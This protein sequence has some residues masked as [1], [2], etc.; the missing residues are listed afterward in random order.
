MDFRLL[1]PVFVVCLALAP[2]PRA[3]AGDGD[4]PVPR[5]PARTAAPTRYDPAAAR[6]VPADFLDD[7]PA[8]FLYSGTTHRIE[9]DGTLETTTFELIRLNGRKGIEQLGQY[10]TITYVP[11]Y[12]SITLHEARIHK[13]RGGVESVTADHVRLRDVNTD[14]LIYDPSKQVVIS[15]PGL[16]VGDVLEVH[17]TTRGKHPEYQGQ[18]FYRYTF[19][20]DRY[21]VARDELTVR[22]PKD[23]KLQFA[24]TNEDVPVRTAEEGDERIYQW[25]MSNRKFLPRGDHQPPL[26]ELMPE[27]VYSTFPT[28]DDVYRWERNLIADRSTCPPEVQKIV[29]EVTR[30]LTDPLPKA[31]ALAQWVRRQVRYISAGEKHDFTPHPPAL[32]LA[33]RYGDCK[34]TAHLLVVM[35]RA[36]G[37]QA[38]LVSFGARGDGQVIESVPSPWGTHAIAVVTI[39]GQEHW[40]DTTATQIGWD[41]LPRDDRDRVCYVTDDRNLR[42]MRTPTLTPEENVTDQTITVSVGTDGSLSG[43]RSLTYRD[44]AAWPRRDDFV[45]TP[46]GESRRLAAAELVDAFP[47]ARLHDL[48][49]DESLNDFDRPLTVR[50]TF[51]VPDYFHRNEKLRDATMVDNVVWNQLLGVTVNPERKA[52]IDL[53][54]P[55]ASNCR[56]VVQLPPSLRFHEVPTPQRVESAWGSFESTVLRSPET[57]HLLEVVVRTRLNKTRV[58]P[59]EFEKF[60]A[61]QEAVQEQYLTRL[62]L[63]PT[64]AAADAPLLEAMLALAPGDAEA[65]ATLAEIYIAG[66]NDEDARRVLERA[67]NFAPTERRLWELSLVATDD[68]REEEELYRQ[69]IDRFPDEAKYRIDL[70]HNLLDQKRPGDARKEL[71]RLVKHADADIRAEAL[72]ELAHCRLL[73]GEPNQA[74][75]DLKA[76]Y[77]DHPQSFDA[78]AWLLQGAAHEELNERDQA[79]AA[80]RKALAKDPDA[81]DV[82]DALVRL[83]IATGARDEALGYLRRFVIA[84]GDDAEG[85]ARAAE[86][87]ARLG[88]FDDAYDLASRAMTET[89]SLHELTRLPLGLALAHRGDFS[90][91]LKHLARVE[92]D[93]LVLTARLRT[94]VA[95]GDLSGAAQDAGRARAVDDPTPELQAAVADVQALAQR[96]QDWRR[97]AAPRMGRTS[98]GQKAMEQFLCADFL[99]SRAEWPTRVD[100][101]L[102]EALAGDAKPGA[103]F[104]LRA[105]LHLERGR[106]AKALTDAEE[107]ITRAADDYRGYFVRGRVRLE[108]GT[109][110]ALADLEKAAGLSQRKDGATLHAFATALVQAGRRAEAL[111]IQREAVSLQP[112]NA[113]FQELL[114]ELEAGK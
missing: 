75:R 27:V 107:A 60:R 56:Y 71:E 28:W 65:A 79:L 90:A 3:F 31:R 106:L 80:Y 64:E 108:R 87:F 2:V 12:E 48:V 114:R 110:G 111:A 91:A 47:K 101:L 10:R 30:G 85:L 74:L 57:P 24:T 94:R 72:I 16:E 86:G 26:D 102:T 70:A 83:T 68:L 9:P 59:S 109:D 13:A 32:V 103:A 8:C 49:L 69:V 21:P 95:L 29:E 63:K 19:G 22:L 44:L 43:E 77:E 6:D 96:L 46:R 73:Q 41:V 82:L 25:A 11:T 4:W 92:P 61:F 36:A 78:E 54:E 99:H 105:V 35:L 34:D 38:G 53:G 97:T 33:Q 37:L 112:T 58:E 67:R 18:N 55:F 93:A 98:P 113:E 39:D 104:G 76:A 14:H 84:V 45:D 81:E 88:R 17:W 66:D 62:K 20:N 1:R 23:R 89:G 100:A 15:F 42:V 51:S 5:G 50:A 7:A 40:I 52:A